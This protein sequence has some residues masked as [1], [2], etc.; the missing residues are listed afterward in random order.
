[1]NLKLPSLNWRKAKSRTVLGVDIDAQGIAVVEM[2]LLGQTV[3]SIRL[4]YDPTPNLDIKDGIETLYDRLAPLLDEMQ[5]QATQVIIAL[6]GHEAMVKNVFLPSMTELDFEKELTVH[7]SKQMPYGT[8][9]RYVDFQIVGPNP[10]DMSQMEVMLIAGKGNIID[11]YKMLFE[12]LKLQLI[13]IDYVDFALRNGVLASLPM[14]KDEPSTVLIIDYKSS[15]L[16]LYNGQVLLK[17]QSVI[18]G[19]FQ[20]L[21]Q[22][23]KK[24]LSIS[25]HL[26]MN[27]AMNYPDRIDQ[28]IWHVFFEGIVQTLEHAWHDSGFEEYHGTLYIAGIGAML[29]DLQPELSKRL[30]LKCERLNPMIK[31]TLQLSEKEQESL[32]LMTIAFGLALRGMDQ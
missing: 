12:Q 29:K 27:I 30:N 25:D 14:Q 4:G 32:P 31:H 7:I 26:A 2:S 24:S 13:C 11:A 15:Q 19:L 9:E 6:R 5:S 8:D 20:D 23:I 28:E 3:R 17:R 1:M 16:M 22:N 10:E 21:M 18:L